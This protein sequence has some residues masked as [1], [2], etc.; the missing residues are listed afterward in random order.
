VT[1]SGLQPGVY[2]ALLTQLLGRRLPAD[3]RLYRLDQVPHADAPAFL[4]HYLAGLI[5][6]VLRAPGFGDDIERRVAFCNRLVEWLASDPDAG[7][8]IDDLI[9]PSGRQLL[10]VYRPPETPLAKIQSLPRPTTPLSQNAL[11]IASKQEPALAGELRRELAS[12]DRVDLL[13]AFVK[14][15]GIRVLLDEI[16]NARARGVPIRVLTTTYT[17]ATE[18]RALDELAAQGVEIRVCYETGATRLHAKA[19]LFE[20]DS[21]FSTAYIGSSNLSHSALHEGLE[22]NVRLT[23]PASAPLLQR[24]R[25]AFET[26]WADPS[27]E[28]YDPD[29]F[30]QALERARPNSSTM[31]TPFDVQP[32][33]FQREMLYQLEVERER[34]QRWRNLIVAATGT[35]KTVVSAFDY[36]HIR[37]QWGEASLLFVAHRQEILQQSLATFRNIVRDGNFGELMV[38]GEKPRQGSHVF[39]SIQSLDTLTR[40]GLDDFPPDAYDVVIVDEFHHAAAP[41][42]QRLLQHLR[43]RLLLGMTATPE[44]TDGFDIKGLFG[45][46]VAVELRLWDALE[47]GLLCPFQYFGVADGTDLSQLS[48]SRGG[49]D[50]GQLDNVYTGNEARVAKVLRALY[51]VVEDFSTMRALGFCV[52]IKH[53]EYMAEC[54]ERAGIPSA[55][56]SANSSQ[57]ERADA[58]RALRDRRINVLFAR[59]LFNEGLD[60]PEI[61]TLLFL[62]P[63]ESPVVFLQQF[64]RGLRRT[65]GKAGVTVLD[66][67]GQQHRR[68]RFE[69]RFRTLIG[70]DRHQ[71]LREIQED[72]PFLPAGCSIKLDRQSEEIILDN[73]R[74]ATR[75]TGSQLSERLREL[76]DVSLA[77]FL[78]SSEFTLEDIYAGSHPGWTEIRRRAGFVEQ[79]GPDEALL[80]KALGRMLHIDDPDRVERYVGWLN[81][82]SPP[83]L[84]R[85]N[86]RGLR[87]AHMLHFDLQSGSPGQTPLRASFDRLWA[88]PNIR[89][90]FKELLEVLGERAPRLAPDPGL[91]PEIPLRLHTRY[92]RNEILAAFGES[93]AEKPTTWREGVKWVENYRMDLFLVTLNK[94]ERHFSPTTRYRDYPIS[95]TLFHWESQ[96][97]TR[98]S[99][100]TGQRYIQHQRTGSRVLLFVRESSVG[101]SL[102]ASP[103]LF[104]GPAS[105]VG[106]EGDRPMAITW[107]LE[108]EMP[109]DFFQ[110]ARVAV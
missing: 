59:D 28:T 84:S 20:R 104:L 2:E 63:T 97:T 50:L 57:A 90:E 22:W 21:G 109:L 56:V 12:A 69:E 101:E 92:S 58:L 38:A 77:S 18:S 3:E 95:P 93:T 60:I 64:G 13:C 51:D 7:M 73:I 55:A 80:S 35:G 26:Y 94:S 45:G 31:I 33:P 53:A 87:L 81:Q 65:E 88:N 48:W 78:E 105:Y 96:S 85:L 36:K 99:A 30:G 37:E 17:G 61:D 10:E 15:S 106:H 19:W 32:Y 47:Q 1:E 5:E 89:G 66:F 71:V 6:T 4:A 24:F 68:F 62:R 43:P 79:I 14:W 72:F 25:A 98:S 82:P 54:F 23:Q 103:F 108:H 91:E 46:H 27:F 49:Y 76:G 107:R 102:G 11:L 41:T 86:A 70:G 39:A 42:Y 74:S 9:D 100:P 29:Q 110:A 67:I 75:S 8:A 16:R 40:S 44:R 34:H 83:D 52:S